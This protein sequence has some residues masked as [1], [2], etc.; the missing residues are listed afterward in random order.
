MKSVQDLILTLTQGV[1]NGAHE[2]AEVAKDAKYKITII[3]DGEGLRFKI[4]I[5]AYEG[6]IE[7]KSTY[8]SELEDYKV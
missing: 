8:R 6:P 1:K 2:F 4:N 3:N 5:G 7:S